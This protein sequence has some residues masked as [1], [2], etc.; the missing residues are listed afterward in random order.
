MKVKGEIHTTQLTDLFQWI[1]HQRKTG[2]LSL[3]GEIVD[4]V[5]YFSQ[6]RIAGARTNVEFVAEGEAQVTLVLKDLLVWKTGSFEFVET[7]LPDSVAATNLQL[8]ISP[9]LTQESG[10]VADA[11]RTVDPSRTASASGTAL[12]PAMSSATNLRSVIIDRVMSGKF[13]IPLLPTIATKVLQIT[14]RE[15]YS[16]NDLSKVILTDQVIAAHVLKQANSALFGGERE[17][18]TLPLAIQRIG[19]DT[20]TKLVFALS[21]QGLRSENDIF[22]SQK[23]MLWK[24]SSACALFARFIAL[25][26]KMD[27]NLA[28]LCG[29]M[30]DFG[31]IVLLSVIQEVAAQEARTDLLSEETVEKILDTYHPMVGSLVGEKW[32]LPSQVVAAMAYHRS[33]ST[34]GEAL[35]YAAI[36]NLSDVMALKLGNLTEEEIATL[37]ADD[38]AM[39]AM[40]EELVLAPAN[41]HLGLNIA[42]LSEL[43]ARAPECLQAAQEFLVI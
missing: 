33:L 17:I 20:V 16:L 43:L 40:T 22:L 31:K 21:L 5:I 41:K 37:Q 6:G 19:S 27:H 26:L 9:F 10:E 4:H 35:L 42:Q 7:P 38:D 30:Q 36:A 18:K 28:F 15:N 8:A 25:P 2:S 24:H 3:A 12:Q 13:K 1:E 14:R 11:V 32:A 29:L 39:H 34:Q 23:K